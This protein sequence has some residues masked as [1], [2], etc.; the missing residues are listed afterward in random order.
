MAVKSSNKFSCSFCNSKNI[1]PVINFG[2]VALAGA[3]LKQAQ[4][5]IEKKYPLQV[6]FCNEC[7]MVQVVN[8]IS[9]EKLFSD[10]FYRS[11]SINTLKSHFTE[12]AREISKR[13]LDDPAEAKVLEFGCNDGVLLKPLLN[14]GI[15]TVIGV[16]PAKNIISKINNKELKLFNDFFQVKLAKKIVSKFGKLDIIMANNVF[17]HIPEINNTTEAIQLALNDDG[18]FIFEVHYLGNVL[19][20]FQYDMIYHEHLYY[21]SLLSAKNHFNKFNMNVFDIKKIPIH[22]GSIRFYVTKFGSKYNKPTKAVINLEREELTKKYDNY[23]TFKI[24]SAKINST[25]QKLN[26]FLLDLKNKGYKIAGYGASGRA[27]TIIQFCGIDT[28]ILD[29]IIDDNPSKTGYFTPGSHIKIYS[30]EVLKEKNPP[31]YILVFAWSF[32]NEIYKRNKEY[33]K[34]GGKFIM[35]LPEVKLFPDHNL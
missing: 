27:N 32:I 24:F 34:K 18:I 6:C 23:E 29:Y 3:F 5:E 31:D 28:S 25:K 17:A 22:G 10:Y 7:F 35:P 1:S 4:F 16:D 12:Y 21:Y 11:S 14:Q 13:F 20:E 19:E 30:R 2:E 9:P 33:V 26:S 8:K 15:K